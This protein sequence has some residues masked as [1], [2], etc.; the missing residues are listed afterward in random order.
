ML[1][2]L[3][4]CNH[5]LRG[6]GVHKKKAEATAEQ[7]AAGRCLSGTEELV[8][9]GSQTLRASRPVL[10][11]AVE[12]MLPPLSLEW[13]AQAPLTYIP[14]NYLILKQQSHLLWPVNIWLR[15]SLLGWCRV[16]DRACSGSGRNGDNQKDYAKPTLELHCEPLL[17][18]LSIILSRDVSGLL[19]NH[20]RDVTSNTFLGKLFHS[21]LDVLVK[22][23]AG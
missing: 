6:G 19:L 3:C 22:I 1:F 20:F 9:Q 17:Y 2:V 7:L 10:Y 11:L 14:L 18:S 13:G 12:T 5:M 15:L 4:A 8:S 21:L 16:L 23:L